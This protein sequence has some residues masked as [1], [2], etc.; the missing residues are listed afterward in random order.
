MA[1]T[2]KQTQAVQ[3]ALVDGGMSAAD[4]LSLHDLQQVKKVIEASVDRAE[5]M[6]IAIAK[7]GAQLLAL[8]V[9]NATS[10][11][12]KAMVRAIEQNLA[13]LNGLNAE[14][15]QALVNAKKGVDNVERNT[16]HRPGRSSE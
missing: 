13:Q 10:V 1:A 7:T 4:K 16:S 2:P 11:P 8:G 6:N 9:E 5:K 15:K 14:Q 12:V 3:S